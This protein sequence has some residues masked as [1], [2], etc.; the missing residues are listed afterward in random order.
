MARRRLLKELR[1]LPRTLDGV[2]LSVG[3]TFTLPDGKVLSPGDAVPIEALASNLRALI[4][5]GYVATSEPVD[6]RYVAPLSAPPQ[7]EPAA[8]TASEEPRLT[9]SELR[10]KLEDAGVEIPAGASKAELLD[11]FSSLS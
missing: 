5:H 3:R 6:Y 2:T 7:P 11:L 9:K 10:A 4:K 1:K 8:E